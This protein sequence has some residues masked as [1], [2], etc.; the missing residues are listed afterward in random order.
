M[1]DLLERLV[2]HRPRYDPGSDEG[3]DGSAE[4][5]NQHEADRNLG[6]QG[7]VTQASDHC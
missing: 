4:D 2:E 6:S 3:G 7:N 5:Y 1:A